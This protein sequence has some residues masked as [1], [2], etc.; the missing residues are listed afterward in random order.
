MAVRLLSGGP[1]EEWVHILDELERVMDAEKHLYPNVDL[2]AAVVNHALGIQPAFYTSVFALSRIVGWTAHAMEGMDGRLVRPV[3]Q[4]VGPL[5]RR[6]ETP[7]L[8]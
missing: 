2:Y 6:L 4:Y 3:A 1:N 7:A 8:P 5:P